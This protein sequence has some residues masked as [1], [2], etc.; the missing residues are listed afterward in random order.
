MR[1]SAAD[2]TQ[3][4]TIALTEFVFMACVMF[5]IN[6]QYGAYS[7]YYTGN[8]RFDLIPRA[9][10]SSFRQK[11]LGIMAYLGLYNFALRMGTDPVLVVLVF[12]RYIEG[13]AE[14]KLPSAALLVSL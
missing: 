1:G 11:T 6:V 7:M 10:F 4:W 2:P 3:V 8:L 14:R 5:I 9:L 12:K 13:A